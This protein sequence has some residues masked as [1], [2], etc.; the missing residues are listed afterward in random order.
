M[1]Q[2]TAVRRRRTAGCSNRLAIDGYDSG[3]WRRD[4]CG[5]AIKYSDHGN[6]YS[7]YGW[8]IDHIK[9]TAKGGETVIDN[10]QPLYWKTNRDKGDSYP[11]SCSS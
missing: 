10:L 2:T 4:K 8:E 9:P 7:E 5:H 6:T 3:V 1:K 11:W